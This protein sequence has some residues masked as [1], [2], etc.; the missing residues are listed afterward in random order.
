MPLL[1]SGV[2]N[3]FGPTQDASALAQAQSDQFI[4]QDYT[5]KT[6]LTSVDGSASRKI[7]Q[8]PTGPLR[9]AV[10]AELRRETYDYSPATVL[11]EGNVGGLGGNSLP[12]SA[13]QTAQAAY[14]ELNG[15]LLHSLQGDIAVRW[16]HY[17]A[18]GST[19]NPQLWLHWKPLH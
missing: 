16:D 13:S 8:L 10:G 19:V 14:F 6:S 5:T 7:A 12:E 1:D 2:I 17:Q 11:Q 4:G 3:P 15:Y 9:L 18:V